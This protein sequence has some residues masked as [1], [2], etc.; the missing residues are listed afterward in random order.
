MTLHFQYNSIIQF[1]VNYNT[2]SFMKSLIK[3]SFKRYDI[4]I[5]VFIQSLNYSCS[6]IWYLYL[7]ILLS[8]RELCREEQPN[9]Y[10]R[11]NGH[12]ASTTFSLRCYL[13]NPFPFTAHNYK[14]YYTNK[15]F[16]LRF[17]MY[18]LFIFQKACAQS[19]L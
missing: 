4:R 11:D 17:I 7:Y 18:Y 9:S 14:H 12:I 2:V 19:R 1:I 3:I 16:L 15:S 8:V 13:F 10:R 6:V 5:S